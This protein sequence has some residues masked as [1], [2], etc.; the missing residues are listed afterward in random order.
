LVISRLSAPAPK[1]RNTF[2]AR[3][4]SRRVDLA[5]EIEDFCDK[6]I[7]L[8]IVDSVSQKAVIWDDLNEQTGTEKL[9]NAKTMGEINQTMQGSGEN[10]VHP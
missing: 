7:D 1:T 2:N 10:R 5:F 9:T 6:L 3:C 8:Q 4:Q